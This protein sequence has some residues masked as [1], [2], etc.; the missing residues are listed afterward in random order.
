MKR[1]SGMRQLTSIIALTVVMGCGGDESIASK[2]AAAYREAKAKGIDV[3]GGHEHGGHAAPAVSSTTS[4]VQ[5][6][7]TDPHA[8]HDMTASAT[9][10][11]H[12]GHGAASMNHAAMG[13]VAATGGHAGHTMPSVGADH[14]AHRSSAAVDHAAMGH[15]PSSSGH[16]GHQTAAR[17]A[18]GH[19][20][21]G[22]PATAADHSQ[23]AGAQ[24]Q[25]AA[26]ADPHAQHRQA[27]PAPVDHSQ[28]AAATPLPAA[29]H[30]GHTTSA[31][32]ASSTAAVS[33]GSTAT[34]LPPA[35]L[36]RDVFDAPAPVS[37][38][39][40]MKAVNGVSHEGHSVRGITPGTDEENPPTPMPAT[41]DRTPSNAAA[42][43]HSQHGAAAPAAQSEA[44][45]Y[46]CPMHPEITSDKPGSCPKCGMALVKK[47]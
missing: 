22:A 20:G 47:N 18:G 39:E 45:I 44:T 6:G 30:A 13:H 32:P 43:D 28:H 40:A 16:A 11:D 34:G 27:T 10:T 2:S 12:A 46:T 31:G 5:T 14:S 17:T 9:A 29:A 35:T 21:H 8:G 26:P 7:A 19:E 36:Q 41:R 38:A 23:H 1:L 15:G 37:I 33:V 24:T 42:A 3:T 4:T 25:P